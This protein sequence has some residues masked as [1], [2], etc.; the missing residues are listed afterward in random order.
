MEHI[1]DVALIKE[2]DLTPATSSS[3]GHPSLEKAGKGEFR[4]EAY[5]ASHLS[6]TNNV[7][8]LVVMEDGELK[9]SDYRKFIIRN[10]KGDDTS[11][12]KEMLSRRLKHKEWRIP[13]FVVVDGGLTQLNA[14]KQILEKFQSLNLL[15]IVAVTKDD[16][17]KAKAIIGEENVI[18]KYKRE[19]LFINSEAHR[20]AI[21]YHRQKRKLW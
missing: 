12:L 20:F 9:K 19:I 14:A 15:K 2:D 4:I 6:G 21:R 7:G 5:D 16:M 3:E 1:Q 8:V 17:H 11:A 18:K 13:D 10:S